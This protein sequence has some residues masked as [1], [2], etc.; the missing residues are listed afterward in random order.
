MS[1]GATPRI[2]EIGEHPLMAEAYPETTSHWSTRVEIAKEDSGG[3]RVT[4]AS[5]PRLARA[6][7]SEAYDVVVVQPVAFRFFQWQAISR[8]L[9]RRSM[10]RGKTP[11]FRSLGQ[12]LINRPVRAPVAIWDMEDYSTIPRQHVF[13]LDR[14]TI[15]FKRELPV[16]HWRVFAGT[17]HW[18]VPTPRFRSIEK[19]K[20]RIEK[21]RPISLGLPLGLDR[22]GL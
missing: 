21:L 7:A 1:G 5:L 10:L 20:R 3:E 16:D 12:E 2:L 14:A 13:L 8:S 17:L 18:Q 4:L 9:F 15:Y 6:L 19:H 22:S 11:Y